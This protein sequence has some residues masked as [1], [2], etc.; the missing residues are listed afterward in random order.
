MRYE[1]TY[2]SNLYAKLQFLIILKLM[3]TLQ[4]PAK[5]EQVYVQRM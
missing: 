3:R 1:H 5:Y 2:F 4:P